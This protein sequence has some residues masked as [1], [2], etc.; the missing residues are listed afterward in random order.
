M[1]FLIFSGKAGKFSIFER[2]QALVSLLFFV[3]IAITV[4]TSAIFVLYTSS[5][6]SS[7]N[8]QG[9]NAYYIAE[10][11]IENAILKLLRDPNYTGETLTLENGTATIQ[12]INGSP[13]TIVSQG[14]SGNSL[15][16][17]Q[18]EMLYNNY[19]LEVVSWKEVY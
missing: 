1:K 13:I 18:A 16:K 9:I 7:E 2:G 12:V 14:E 11:G 10:T 8:E 3:L 6:S 15:K 17:I 5:Q 4:T 19:K